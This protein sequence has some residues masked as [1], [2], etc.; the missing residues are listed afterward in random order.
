MI[1]EILLFLI[2]FLYFVIFILMSAALIECVIEKILSKDNNQSVREYSRR[3]RGKFDFSVDDIEQCTKNSHEF[4][5][6]TVIYKSHL[7]DGIVI[8][9]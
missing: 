6:Q 7:L 2:Y 5:R 3:N 4:G 1:N 9:K 8:E